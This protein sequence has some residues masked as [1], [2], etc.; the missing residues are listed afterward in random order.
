[1]IQMMVSAFQL[2]QNII[3]WF[4]LNYYSGIFNLQELLRQAHRSDH[5]L[6]LLTVKRIATAGDGYNLLKSLH[7]DDK[8]TRKFVVLNCNLLLAKAM[9]GFHIQDTAMDEASF[10]YLLTNLVR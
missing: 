4:T 10:H 8:R 5:S 1:M 6:T 9:I 3:W 7:K 2:T